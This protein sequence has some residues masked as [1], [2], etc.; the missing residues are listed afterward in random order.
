MSTALESR[1][2]NRV[3]ARPSRSDCKPAP[4]REAAGAE[5]RR[6]ARGAL[7]ATRRPVRLRRGLAALGHDLPGRRDRLAPGVRRPRRGG[8]REGGGT[9]ARGALAGGRR[10]SSPAHPR[11]LASRRTRRRC[12]PRRADAGDGVR[13]PRH[14]AGLSRGTG[15]PHRPRRPRRRLLAAREGLAPASSRDASTTRAFRTGRTRGSGWSR[16]GATSS[17]PR[18]THVERRGS[19]GATSRR[20]ARQ[21]ERSR[22][23]TRTWPPNR[24]RSLQS[25]LATSTC[26]RSRSAAALGRAHA[27]SVGRYRTDLSAEQLADV[28]DEAGTLLREL[29]Y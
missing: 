15:R 25:S 19:G 18:A 17:R 9:G 11:P 3:R 28:E 5:E 8:A 7:R 6:V 4:R 24:R 1:C 23:D 16:N 13:R 20:R 14:S 27:S 22:S 2:E 21:T 12:A 10:C 26:L 29:G